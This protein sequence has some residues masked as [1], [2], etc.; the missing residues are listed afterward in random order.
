MSLFA[1][2]DK[3]NDQSVPWACR[4]VS[5]T[6]GSTSSPWQIIISSV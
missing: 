6:Y 2:F 3:L 1:R 5:Y 4:R